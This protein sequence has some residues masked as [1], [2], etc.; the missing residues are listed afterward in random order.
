[1]LFPDTLLL[2]A[3]TSFSKVS[4]QGT[5]TN[6]SMLHKST[7]EGKL[8]I[9]KQLGTKPVAEDRVG[10]NDPIWGGGRGAVG[11]K[12]SYSQKNIYYFDPKKIKRVLSNELD[13]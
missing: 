2:L 7:G 4:S 9:H 11:V 12:C 10:L 5:Q 6:P 1:M 13:C 8:V 3:L